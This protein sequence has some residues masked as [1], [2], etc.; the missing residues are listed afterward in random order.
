M[1]PSLILASL[2]LSTFMKSSE[3]SGGSAGRLRALWL[4]DAAQSALDASFNAQWIEPTLA[5]VAWVSRP[6]EGH[7]DQY[8]YWHC[9]QLLTLFE[10]CAHPFH[11]AERS[12]SS[13]VMLDSIIRSLALTTIDANEPS[14]SVFS[15][16]A[17]PIVAVPSSARVS[18]QEGC[19]CRALTLGQVSH[20]SHEHTPLWV[21]TAAW[22]PDWTYAEI[23]KE[24]SR[25]L[26]WSALQLAAG[27]TSHAAAFAALPMDYYCIQPAN[28]RWCVTGRNVSTDV[29]D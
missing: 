7:T 15:P 11:S 27:H 2:A 14:A 25:R 13:M 23:R 17:V 12:S 24:E 21:A 19:S 3:L 8:A 6:R 26:C 18:R 4:R 10:L 20:S 28:V 5:Q 22:N 1:Q 29:G 9:C 16:R